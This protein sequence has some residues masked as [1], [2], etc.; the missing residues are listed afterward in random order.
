VVAL[1]AGAGANL[2]NWDIE[3]P[4]GWRE[5]VIAEAGG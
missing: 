3:L 5:E 4:P 2:G 1:L